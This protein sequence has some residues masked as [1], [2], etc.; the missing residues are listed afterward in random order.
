MVHLL[1]GEFLEAEGEA[2]GARAAYCASY[3]AHGAGAAE[4]F[5]AGFMADGVAA[6]SDAALPEIE[7]Y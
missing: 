5:A 1:H 6:L 3:R 7:R 4:G 2:T